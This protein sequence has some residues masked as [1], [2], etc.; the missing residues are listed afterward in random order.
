MHKAFVALT[1][2]L[3]G[4]QRLDTARHAEAYDIRFD[5]AIPRDTLVLVGRLVELFGSE[6]EP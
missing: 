6:L 4:D 3:S 1:D 5:P 2:R